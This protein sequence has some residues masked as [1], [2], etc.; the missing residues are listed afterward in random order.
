MSSEIPVAYVQQFADDV[1]HLAQ[2]KKSKLYGTVS[3]KGKITGK[4]W[5]YERIGAT[6][7]A[8][9]TTRAGDTPYTDTPH[10]RRHGYCQPY[11]NA[12]TLDPH[13]EARILIAPKN[14][15][16]EAF[17]MAEGRRID[18]TIIAAFNATVAS[19]ETPTSG[20]TT[21]PTT[22]I[23][24]ADGA[25]NTNGSSDSSGTLALTTEKMLRALALLKAQDVDDDDLFFAGHPMSWLNLQNTTKYGSADYNAVK[26]IVEGNI[27]RWSG[28]NCVSCTRL[29]IVSGTSTVRANWAYARS[30]IEFA[31]CADRQ[32]TVDRL[33]TKSNAVQ[34]YHS[35]DIGALRTQEVCVVQVNADESKST[36]T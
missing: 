6:S 16:A 9:K 2:Q 34:I 22:Q 27:V 13:D 36:N 25:I 30:A 35:L 1:H 31:E 20:T 4:S 18:D 14:K 5:T 10:T 8:A 12:D 19:G 7:M 26:S 23:I 21:F 17:S 32:M 29:G 11:H 24:Y 28:F 3:L 33:P 15:Y